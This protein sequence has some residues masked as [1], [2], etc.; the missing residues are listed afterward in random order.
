MSENDELQ[1]S[2]PELVQP[3]SQTARPVV[4][5]YFMGSPGQL[6]SD[7][8]MLMTRTQPLPAVGA[9]T[10]NARSAAASISEKFCALRS[11]ARNWVRFFCAKFAGRVLRECG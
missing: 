7:G 3:R 9:S 2:L 6:P 8:L 10:A 5:E 11:N 4:G 1:P